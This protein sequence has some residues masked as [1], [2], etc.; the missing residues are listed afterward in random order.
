VLRRTSGS[1]GK[2]QLIME[3]SSVANPFASTINDLAQALGSTLVGRRLCIATAESCTGGAIAHAITSVPGSSG[4]F[5]RGFVV[6]SNTAKEEILGVRRASLEVFGAVSE[7][8]AKEM[9]LG[10][11]RKS[12]AAF[13]VAVTGIAGPEGGTEDKPVGTVWLAWCVEGEIETA[14]ICFGGDRNQVRQGATVVALQ[15]LLS[16]IQLWLAEHAGE[17]AF[18][19]EPF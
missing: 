17:E 16:R 5:D 2:Q 11:F 3:Q 12:H 15:G 14:R 7:R 10:A 4:W 9:A 1:R 13:T 6:Y 19:A 18:L 8:V